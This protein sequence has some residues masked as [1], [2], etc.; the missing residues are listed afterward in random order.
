ML[1]SRI[2]S[3]IER[4]IDRRQMLMELANQ[5][6]TFWKSVER[7]ECSKKLSQKQRE[8]IEAKIQDI[9]HWCSENKNAPKSVIILK[10]HDIKELHEEYQKFVNE[11]E[12]EPVFVGIDFGTA[13]CCISVIVNKEFK[14]IE[15]EDGCRIPSVVTFSKPILI[16]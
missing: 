10:Q 5:A 9:T 8:Q 11:N 15:I 14:T 2:S 12:N 13:N 16:G 3:P 1:Y 4:E 6:A 7:A